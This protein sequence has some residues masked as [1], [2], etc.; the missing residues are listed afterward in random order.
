MANGRIPYDA[1]LALENAELV[2]TMARL[3]W[4]GCPSTDKLPSKA[5]P[6][7]ADHNVPSRRARP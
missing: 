2:A 5:L 4:A 1:K 3:P 6:D 7:S